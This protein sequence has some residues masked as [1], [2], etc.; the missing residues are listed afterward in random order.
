MEIVMK[1]TPKLIWFLGVDL[2]EWAFPISFC[3]RPGTKTFV[4]RVLCFEMVVF[5]SSYDVGEE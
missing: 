2:F 5:P 3:F 4:L 1:K